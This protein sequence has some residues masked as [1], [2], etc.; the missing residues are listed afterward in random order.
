MFVGRT[1]EKKLLQAAVA[2]PGPRVAL[3]Y[4]RRRVGKT[5]LIRAA[6]GKTPALF[7]EGLENQSQQSQIATFLRQ[8]KEQTGKDAGPATNW[9]DA[10]LG[11]HRVLGKKRMVI[12]LD[13]FQWLA[14]YRQELISALKMVWENYLSRMPGRTLI[15]CGSIASFMTTKVL[16]GS[17]FHGRVDT[18]VH[19]QGFLLAETAALLKGRGFS[20]V[21]DAQSFTGGVPKYLELLAGAPSVQLGME[22][23]A[24]T[25]NGYFVDEYQRIFVSHF[26]KNAEYE[27]LVRALAGAPYGLLRKELAAV[28]KVEEGG[29]LSQ[30]LYDLEAAGFIT[31]HRPF[32]KAAD[33]RLIRYLLSD[34][35]MSFYY[36]F[37]RPKLKQIQTG[38]RTDLFAAVRQSGAFRSWMGRAFELVCIRHTAQLAAAL[39]FAGVDYEAGPWFRAPR[40]QLPGVQIDLAFARADHV[41]TLCEMKRQSAPVGKAVI[42]EVERKAAILQGE[43]PRHTIQRVLVSDGPVSREVERSGY[44]FRILTAS[45]LV[46]QA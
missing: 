17:A 5:S 34:P 23:E 9:E 43:Y 35:W 18:V 46:D 32:D 25:A 13:E 15:L 4:G 22:R 19:L 41:I 37:L 1:S 42:A 2:A 10:L 45:E 7:I 30:R 12:V 27:R 24:F 29:M 33:S 8:I 21:L 16:R 36:A 44:F 6:L 14:N 40:R 26:G 38:G 28:A 11:L 20:E 31:S 3:I 39:G